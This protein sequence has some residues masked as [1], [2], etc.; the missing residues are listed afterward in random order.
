[1]ITLS[2]E[3]RTHHRMGKRESYGATPPVE[4]TG[5][6]GTLTTRGPRCQTLG[7]KAQT[8]TALGR[9]AKE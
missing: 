5:P 9:R 1:M 7:T 8:D 2:L 6:L 4:T 3:A